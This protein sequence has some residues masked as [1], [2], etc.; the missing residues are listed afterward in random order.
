MSCPAPLPDSAPMRGTG[1][2]GSRSGEWRVGGYSIRP[3]APAESEPALA[4]YRAVGVSGMSAELWRWRFGGPRGQVAA[5]FDEQGRLVGLYPATVR[6]VR[7]HGRDLTAWQPCWTVVHPEVRWGGRVFHLLTRYARARAREQGATFAFGGG[8]NH[9]A[10]TVGGRIAGYRPLLELPVYERRL[11][12]RL[13][14]LR[15]LGR[16]FGAAADLLDTALGGRLRHAVRDFDLTVASA[17]GPEFDQLWFRERDA[18][19]VL[20]RRDAREL[21]W[22]WFH[23]PEPAMVLVARRNRRLFGYAALR[24]HRENGVRLTTVLDLFSGRDA[25]AAEALVC[26]A[27]LLSWAHRSDFLRLAC[28]GSS[29]AAPLM[30]R[31][32]W[33]RAATPADHVAFAPLAP[34][35]SENAAGDGA[36]WYYCQ[37]DSD[38]LD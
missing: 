35:E 29:P 11:S 24:H 25:G 23:C 15:K 1:G 38:F 6:P 13:G 5:A 8:V 2:D 17:A 16:S 10:A 28:V 32:P 4:L 21:D 18:F 9:A 26:G 33:R 14:L 12:L 20:V 34:S 37:G 36:S 31:K 19:P 3:L 27:S 7:A 30:Q 22:R